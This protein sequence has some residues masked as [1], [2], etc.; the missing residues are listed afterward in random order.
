MAANPE[1]RLARDWARTEELFHAALARPE[2]EREAW[3][4]SQNAD[5]ELLEG[6]RS[7]LQAHSE[8]RR[9]QTIRREVVPDPPVIPTEHF[10][11]YRAVRLLGRG[12]MSAVYLA[13]RADGRFERNVAVK[14]MAAHLAGQ[15][16]PR[17]FQNEGRL[18]AALNHPNIAGLLDGGVS[19]SGYPYLLLEYV[20]GERLD[21]YC[22]NRKLGIAERLRLFRQ[23]CEAVDYAHQKQILH[24]DLKP[25]NILVT[26]DGVVK[27]LDFGTAALMADSGN[28][29]VTRA[30]MLTPRYAS[31]EQLQGRRPGAAGDVF[32]LGVVLY[33]L[34]T[35]A[36]PFGNPNSVL[37][38]LKRA[39][40]DATPLAMRAAITEEAA[41]LRGSSPEALR[42]MLAG[43]LEAITAK[44]LEND[45]ARRYASARE[46]LD[47]L[48]RLMEGLPVRAS[49]RR[50]VHAARRWLQ[51][52]WMIAAVVILGAAGLLWYQYRP[53]PAGAAIAKAP[54]SSIKAAND[55]FQLGYF[56]WNR[57]T[58]DSLEKASDAFRQATLLDPKFAMAYAYLADSEAMLPEYGLEEV[59]RTE[60]GRSAARRALA[61][62]ANLWMAHAALAWIAFSY[63]WNWTAAEPEFRSAIALAPGAA[64]P[65][66]RYGLALISRGRFDEAEGQLRTAQQT[67]PVSVLP[68]INQAELWY[69][70][71][72]FDREEEQLQRV[73][74]LD[75]HYVVAR[76]MLTKLKIVSGRA[77]EGVAEAERLYSGPEGGDSWCQA[78]AEAYAG[79]GR[80]ADALRQLSKCSSVTNV[81]PG[82]Y[83]RLGDHQRAIDILEK[84]YRIR[85]PYLQY[86]KVDPDYDSL[87]AEP[88]FQAL[89]KKVGL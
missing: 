71:R 8:S 19:A 50:W 20:A 78:L 53:R 4:R 80:R 41:E 18:L 47:D 66:Q 27:L 67:D 16:F 24:R 6:V 79:A 25:D 87:R 83:M 63:D 84:L 21:H 70:S 12:G 7:L 69:Y 62:D 77:N 57:H 22:D 9:S 48:N 46:L 33:E 89:V 55:A 30:R 72:H 85:D 88:R 73:L 35:G 13:E 38:E 60:E 64:L 11:A 26:A 15:D 36:W 1:S 43:R 17:R 56:H 5:P 51:R 65:H 40:G 86:L 29:T 75:P 34:L 28:V 59:R 49:Q 45:S 2:S 61:L 74:E 37:S 58:R 52:S 82:T 32:S 14:L 42:R 68:K 31:P 10:G 3:L 39:A 76:A 44:A 81:I 23:I 54:Q